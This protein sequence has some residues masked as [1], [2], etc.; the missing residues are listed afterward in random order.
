[1]K[2]FTIAAAL[3]FVLSFPLSAADDDGIT[4]LVEYDGQSLPSD[5]TW[6]KR[7]QLNAKITDGT[8]HL[9]DDAVEAGNY[10]A[11]W[12]ADPDQE[13]I[14]EVKV[15]MG[16]MTGWKKGSRAKS[17]WPWRDGAPVGL[18]ISDGQH[19]EGLVLSPVQAASFTDRF[20]PMDT[21]NRFHTYRLV[22][23]G[24]NM[25][26]WVDGVKKVEGQ[27]AF[28]KPASSPQAFIQFGSTA[29]IASGDAHWASVRLGV[30]NP[31]TPP[32]INPLKITISEAW[33]IPRE[34]AHQTRPY[35]YDLGQDLLLMSV[36]QGSDAFYEHYGLLKSTDAGKSWLPVEGLDKKSITPLPVLR[37]PDGSIL[38]VS[39]WT[40]LQ[41]DGSVQGKTF[42]L[43]AKANTFSMS[44]NTI[45]LPEKYSNE[46][47]NDKL[48]VERHIWNDENGAMTMVVWSR[49]GVPISGGR[50]GTERMSHLVRSTDDGKTWN[51]ISTL[52][53]GGE[54]AVVRLSA[55]EM[56]AVIRGARTTQM[57]QTFS[58]DGGATW[59]KPIALEVGRVAPDLVL[60][61]NGV[62]AC[63]YGRPAS[64]IMFSI[65]GGKTWCTHR[66][67]SDLVGFNYCSIREISPGR[68]LLVHDAPKMNAVYIDVQRLD[69]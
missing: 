5:A 49:K 3:L 52:G 31:K 25:S 63:S 56:T 26:M 57:T 38:A 23:R 64:C 41:K 68:L 17:L 44:D 18:L 50:I 69:Q 55:T 59:D 12:K 47:E 33:E 4:W 21:T 7:G 65:D 6:E 51:Y 27:N 60:M 39:R 2:I 53:P 67:V 13:I 19:Q 32:K 28:W 29:K 40:W 36:A 1:M 20:I 14:V 42:H 58:H 9:V 11:S 43:D 24:T 15:K 16:A 35:L 10:R 61:S 62:L 46:V 34:D 8:L 37:R 48:I 30:R 45:V 54:P 22:I 66:V